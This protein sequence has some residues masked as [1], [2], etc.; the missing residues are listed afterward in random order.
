MMATRHINRSAVR[1]AM[2]H[3]IAIEILEEIYAGIS[4]GSIENYPKFSMRLGQDPQ[5]LQFINSMPAYLPLKGY[6][7]IKWASVSPDNSTKGMPTAMGMIVLNDPDNG[8]PLAVMDGGYINSWRTGITTGMCAYYAA[9][10]NSRVLTVIGPGENNF[11]ALEYLLPR[12][13]RLTTVHVI[14]RNRER[15]RRFARQFAERYRPIA[16]PVADSP[17]VL[18]SSDIILVS[19]SSRQGLLDG[20]R[21]KE[22]ACVVGA[23][24]FLDLGTR[25]LG[26]IDLIVY[27]QRRAALKRLGEPG[28]VDLSL[29]DS[30]E[31]GEAIAQGGIRRRKQRVL[32]VPVGLAV[33]DLAIAAHVYEHAANE[34]AFD[35]QS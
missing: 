12:M 18:S 11:H 26:Q 19:T 24:G 35:Y 16:F 34:H 29:F 20:V 8:Y 31:L 27:D 5:K 13:P 25:F 10:R 2:I 22:G 17:A 32:A 1:K 6:V 21:L 28:S 4:D 3:D 9:D 14:G 30:V 23:N 7:G 33:I 15:T